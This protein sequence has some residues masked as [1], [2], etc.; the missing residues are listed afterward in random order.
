MLSTINCIS[1]ERGAELHMRKKSCTCTFLLENEFNID[2]SAFL[3]S[4]PPR[5]EISKRTVF[6]MTQRTVIFIVALNDHKTNMSVI[7][8]SEISHDLIAS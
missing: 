6:F 1:S 5:L 8:I 4:P 7:I 2:R 3:L